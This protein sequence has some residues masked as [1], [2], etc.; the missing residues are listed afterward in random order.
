MGLYGSTLEILNSNTNNSII[1]FLNYETSV[2]AM[3]SG[4]DW[5][6]THVETLYI[7]DY[8]ILYF[9]LLNSVYDESMDFFFLSVWYSTLQ[10]SSL[11]LFWSVVLDNY[12]TGNLFQ[13]NLTD[14]WVRSYMSGKDSALFVIYHPEVIFFKNQIYNNYLFEFLTDINISAIQYLDSQSL[15]SPIML[16]PQLLFISYVGFFF[17]SFY[18]SSY[19]TP[20]KEESTID[21][22][23]LSA[24]ITVES[25]KEL[26]SIDDILMPSVILIYTF[27]W[28]FYTHCWTLISTM[29]ETALFFFFLPLLYYTIA[30]TPTYLL[31]DFGILYTCY[32][33]G[34]VPTPN[35]I[36]ELV[37]DYVSVICYYIRI[38][39]QAVRLA[40]MFVAYAGLHDFVLYTHYDNK[41]L[42]GNES[43]WEE[44]SNINASVSSITYFLLGVLPGFILSWLYEIFHT[45]FV[46]T[47][48]IVAYFGMI[49]WL[50]IYLF[51][52]FVIEKQENYFQ[53]RKKFR[54]DLLKKIQSI[55]NK[56]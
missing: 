39:T 35:L 10:V 37:F 25:E 51:T 29:P 9:W 55:K 5:I 36:F 52:F 54:Q 4:I 27:G 16:L 46:V 14:E 24:S 13:F 8:K 23:Y 32:L 45:F 21:S 11:Q 22:D 12:V 6:Y 48:Q 1:L 38:M 17:V 28:Y 34:V 44:I 33:K 2:H 56:G 50:F 31:Y 42:V 15:L 53:E 18:F 20:S 40:L 30:N 43:I 19:S 3:Y 7:Y 47:G 41:G 26:G 49:F